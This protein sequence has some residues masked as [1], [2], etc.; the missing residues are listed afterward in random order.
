MNNIYRCILYRHSYMNNENLIDINKFASWAYNY[1]SL[2]H[3]YQCFNPKY[4]YEKDY[5][6]KKYDQNI[7]QFYLS[8]SPD[9]RKVLYEYIIQRYNNKN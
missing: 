7:L 9:Q 2:H 1:W 4:S 3:M 6:R 5:W 8:L